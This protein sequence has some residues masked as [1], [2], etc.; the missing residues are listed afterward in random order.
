MTGAEIVVACKERGR[1]A[2][3][4]AKVRHSGYDFND[5]LDDNPEALDNPWNLIR[6][7][8]AYRRGSMSPTS[9]L[10]EITETPEAR[11]HVIFAFDDAIPDDPMAAFSLLLEKAEENGLC[12]CGYGDWTWLIVDGVVL[13][14]PPEEDEDTR[15]P[16]T[17]II[18]NIS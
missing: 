13:M 15:Q 4:A 17:T 10:A 1:Y 6:S 8:F 9:L 14:G 5:F 3:H 16:T 12:R 7:Y 2:V 11:E 18:I